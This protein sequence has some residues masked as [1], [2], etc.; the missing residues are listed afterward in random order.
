M[1]KASK[2]K[3]AQRILQ[4]GEQLFWKQGIRKVTVEELCQT[5]KVSKMT[6][7]RHFANKEQ[8]ALQILHQMTTE[9]LQKFQSIM[10][11][12]QPFAKKLEA[13]IF[14]KI[15]RSEG[16]S[17]AFVNDI[18]Q[19]DFPALQSYLQK[20]RQHNLQLTKM[21]FAKA[22]TKGEIR[23]DLNLDFLLLVFEDS[24]RILTDQRYLQFHKTPAKLIEEWMNILFYGIQSPE[25]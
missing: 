18:L 12:D 24:T 1:N 9:G 3:S 20:Q 13:I 6:F 8:L 10:E 21:Y 19:H 16:M 14:W 5:A 25:Q 2:S 15:K 17:L 22:Q 11:A 7:Y 4:S 23:A